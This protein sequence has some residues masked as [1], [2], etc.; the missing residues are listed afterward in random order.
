MKKSLGALFGLLLLAMAIPAD[1]GS[2]RISASLDYYSLQDSLYKDI[3]G[4]GNLMMGGSLNYVFIRRFEVRAEAAYFLD[5]GTMTATQEELKFRLVPLLFGVRFRFLQ[6]KFS[7]YLGA[8]MGSYSY[9]E[10]YPERFGNVSDSTFGYHLESGGYYD[11]ASRLFLDF[12]VRYT[13]ADADA[14]DMT[15]KLGGFKIGIGIGYRFF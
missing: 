4:S 7:P 2:L 9:K 8:G 14:Y 15:V 11:L 10:Y 13:K 3:Y 12:N 6:K 1:S 5:K